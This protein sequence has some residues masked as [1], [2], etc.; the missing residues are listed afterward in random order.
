LVA[1]A[2]RTIEMVDHRDELIHSA[3]PRRKHLAITDRRP[4]T[5]EE[6]VHPDL[7]WRRWGRDDK[8]F[9]LYEDGESPMLGTPARKPGLRLST[10]LTDLRKSK[11]TY[12]QRG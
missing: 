7:P 12:V 4:S 1:V 10:A 3:T 11:G 5:D 9:T 2:R 8:R 6:L